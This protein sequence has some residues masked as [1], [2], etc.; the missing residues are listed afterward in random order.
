MLSNLISSKLNFTQAESVL[1]TTVIIKQPLYLYMNLH[2]CFFSSHLVFSQSVE[3]GQCKSSWVGVRQLAKV[4][5]P[6]IMV[7]FFIFYL[8]EI[9]NNPAPSSSREFQ[10]IGGEF[11]HFHIRESKFVTNKFML[12][13][14]CLQH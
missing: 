8:L 4:N 1:P 2:V 12:R 14:H 7:L 3:E 10:Q 13:A 6:Q 5:T 9:K 11:R